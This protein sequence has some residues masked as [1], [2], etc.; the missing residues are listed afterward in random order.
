MFRKSDKDRKNEAIQQAVPEEKFRKPSPLGGNKWDEEDFL[1]FYGVQ[2]G[3]Q[4]KL[5]T[6]RCKTTLSESKSVTVFFHGLNEHLGLYA[7][8]A[9]AVSKKANSVVV[10][11][12]FRGFGKSQGLRG[13]VESREQLLNDCQRFIMQIRTMYPRL[14]L[15]TLGQSMGGMASYLMGLNDVCEGTILIT[16]A[17]L[18]N[19][20]NQPFMKKL[21]LCFGACF[22]TWNPFPPVIVTGSRNPQILEDNLKD[23]YCV[24]VAVLPGTGRVLVST[25]RSLPQT[26]TQYKKP[27]LVISAGMDQIV[28]PDVGH[29]LMKQ[30]PSQDKQMIHYENMWHDCVQEEEIIEIIPKIVD[31]ISQ[32]SIK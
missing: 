26:F 2:K 11:F 14:P 25:M 27:F 18:D 4:I 8:I 16:P 31:W 19:Y 24:Q 29:E 7:H 32:R 22:P 15:F 1:E 3:Q 17:I 20:Y 10:G 30:S 9:Q 23:P 5:H 21:G 13:W 6:Y 12:D 28:D